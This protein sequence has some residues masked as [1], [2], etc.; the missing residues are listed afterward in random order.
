ML[1]WT[2]RI[3]ALSNTSCARD[4]DNLKYMHL[5]ELKILDDLGRNE[6]D[7][8]D[9]VHKPPAVSLQLLICFERL[10]RPTHFAHRSSY[11]G[12]G[13]HDSSKSCL[14]LKSTSSTSTQR[15]KICIS[16]DSFRYTYY[17]QS[18]YSLERLSAPSSPAH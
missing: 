17:E 14:S 15:P 12:G 11:N 2:R 4:I 1:L 9:H 6:E 16:I 10:A 3:S 13:R 18:R 5:P 7:G 8:V